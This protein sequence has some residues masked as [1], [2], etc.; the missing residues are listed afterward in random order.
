VDRRLLWRKNGATGWFRNDRPGFERDMMGWCRWSNMAGGNF[1][2]KWRFELE[3]IYIYI[4]IIIYY[5]YYPC[6]IY[7]R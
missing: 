7:S 6:I 1:P 5:Y 2:D 4:I 3:E